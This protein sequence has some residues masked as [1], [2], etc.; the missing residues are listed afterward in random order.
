MDFRHLLWHGKVTRKGTKRLFF[1]AYFTSPIMRDRLNRRRDNMLF[2]RLLYMVCAWV[3]FMPVIVVIMVLWFGYLLYLTKN[4]K[5]AAKSWYRFLY[6]G[7]MMN[8]D[9]VKNGL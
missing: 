6:S 8:V 7:V 1:F 5:T 4:I 9:F 3:V 2:V